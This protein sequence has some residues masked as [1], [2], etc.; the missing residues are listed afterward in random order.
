MDI[1]IANPTSTGGDVQLW[2][3]EWQAL[4]AVLS[5]TR[6]GVVIASRIRA[7]VPMMITM[8]VRLTMTDEEIAVL[9]AATARVG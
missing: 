9:E 1:R 3:V 5:T 7:D 8:P 4:I 2:P 6:E